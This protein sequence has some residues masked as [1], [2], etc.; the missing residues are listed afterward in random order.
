MVSV[1]I[2]RSLSMSDELCNVKL[3]VLLLSCERN[4]WETDGKK[5]LCTKRIVNQYFPDIWHC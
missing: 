3:L 4:N 5:I 1:N 2:N